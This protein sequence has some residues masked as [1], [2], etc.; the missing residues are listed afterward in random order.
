MALS[1]MTSIWFIAAAN[2][3]AQLRCDPSYRGRVMS[4]WGMAMSGTTP[5]PGFAA[6]AVIEFAGP[7]F[8]FSVSGGCPALAAVAG[9]RALRD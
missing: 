1:G 4:L 9:W 6:A 8:G 7:R 2:T 3:L 5:V